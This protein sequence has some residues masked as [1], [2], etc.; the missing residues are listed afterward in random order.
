VPFF[1]IAGNGREQGARGDADDT[2]LKV[3]RA[4][5]ATPEQVRLAWTLQRGRHVLAIPGTGNPD[6]LIANVAAA[7]L[8]LSPDEM[9]LL[10]TWGSSR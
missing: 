2:P 5:E 4:H 6:H 1:A 3:A 9:T 7:G 10:S 8:R